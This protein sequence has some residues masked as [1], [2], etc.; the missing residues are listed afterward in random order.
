MQRHALPAGERVSE[1]VVAPVPHLVARVSAGK[2][3]GQHLRIEPRPPSGEVDPRHEVVDFD[4]RGTQ[5]LGNRT[6]DRRLA[7]PGRTIHADETDALDGARPR[8]PRDRLDDFWLL[9]RPIVPGQAPTSAG[10]LS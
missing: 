8:G 10:R 2:Q 1:F 5:H 6:R 4:D 9:H 3:R 7:R